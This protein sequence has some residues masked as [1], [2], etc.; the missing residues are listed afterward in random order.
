VGKR[1]PGF[2]LANRGTARRARAALGS[3]LESLPSRPEVPSIHA[4]EV[5]EQGDRTEEPRWFAGSTGLVTGAAHGIGDGIAQMLANLGARVV[6]VDRDAGALKQNLRGAAYVRCRGDLGSGEVA[7]LAEDLWRQHGPIDLL[8]NNVGID[9]PHRFTELGEEDF[10][11]VFRTNLRGPWFFTK[12]LVERMLTERRRG[13]VVFVSS[14]HDTFIRSLPHYSASKAAVSMLVKEL[15]QELAPHGIRVNAVSPGVVQSAHV[16]A[17]GTRKEIE[18]IR[19]I[20]P[21]GRMGVSKEV[22]RMV[23]VLLSDEWAGYVT[24]ANVRVDGGLGLHS[25]S[26]HPT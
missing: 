7:E 6:A 21:L 3:K 22:A 17:P 5:R 15:A 16:P 1:H 9:T 14:L 8:V 25:W 20:V 13:A 26:V 23:A 11:L 12:R 18:E 24:G 2:A 19:S 10:D 4:D